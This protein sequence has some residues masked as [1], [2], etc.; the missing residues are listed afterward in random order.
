MEAISPVPSGFAYRI[1]I[2]DIVFRNYLSNAPVALTLI[3]SLF[4]NFP[5]VYMCTLQ[6]RNGLAGLVIL[7]LLGDMP[8]FNRNIILIPSKFDPGFI[9]FSF[10]KFWRIIWEKKISHPQ[11][12]YYWYI[13][14]CWRVH[15]WFRFCAELKYSIPGQSKQ[16]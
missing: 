5:T 11:F 3:N 2:R 14:F 16:N 10:K 7:S 8:H 1:Y 9:D 6:S 4:L 12:F 15:G 13:F